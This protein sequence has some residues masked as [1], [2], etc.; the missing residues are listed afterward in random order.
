MHAKTNFFVKRMEFVKFFEGNFNLD[1]KI[2]ILNNLDWSVVRSLCFVH[3]GIRQVCST[4]KFWRHRI[5]LEGGTEWLPNVDL[6]LKEWVKL[7]YNSVCCQYKK[8]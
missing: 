5:L 1:I 8:K 4:S 2:L 7:Y 3:P 6:S